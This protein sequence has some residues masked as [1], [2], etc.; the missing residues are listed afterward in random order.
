[1]DNFM[2]TCTQ[3]NVGKIN[4]NKL[5]PFCLGIVMKVL[6]VTDLS[7]DCYRI[8]VRCH[9]LGISSHLC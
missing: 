8:V 9:Q 7:S 3:W 1:M 5:W 2:Y 4:D 6:E